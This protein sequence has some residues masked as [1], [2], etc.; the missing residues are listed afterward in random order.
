MGQPVGLLILDPIQMKDRQNRA[1]A[2]GAKKLID[3]A[4]K[5]PRVPFPIRRRGNCRNDLVPD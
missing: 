2:N 1:I 5:S 3:V 4:M